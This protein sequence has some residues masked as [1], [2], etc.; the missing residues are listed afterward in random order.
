MTRQAFSAAVR[1]VGAGVGAREFKF[2]AATS[3]LGRDGH[4]I[5]PAGIALNNYKRNP[6]VLFQHRAENPVA[7]CTGIAVVDGEL[8]GSAEFPPLGTSPLADEVCGLVKSG[9]VSAVS[10]GFEPTETEP[11]DPKRPRSGLR[12][13]RC[14]LLECSLVTIPAD[15]GAIV[16][17]RHWRSNM[18]SADA[19]RCVRES[20]DIHRSAI[21]DHRDAIRGHERAAR[22][23]E[24]L[25]AR[26]GISRTAVRSALA[27]HNRALALHRRAA[28]EH[29]NCVDELDD[30]LDRSV[31]SNPANGD[32]LKDIHNSQSLQTSAGVSKGTSSYTPLSRAQR[33]AELLALAGPV[34]GDGGAVGGAVGAAAIRDAEFIRRLA[35]CQAVAAAGGALTRSP[36]RAER[37][38]R[39][40]RLARPFG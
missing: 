38:E 28:D 6:V 33:Q 1:A 8:R 24:G 31:P 9:V 17:E 30:L 35:H 19:R 14:E 5:I 36:T 32:G 2:V 26:G 10:I 20:I 18:L 23:V 16:T 3:Q 15:V 25:V 29:D 12:I 11:L 22:L 7:R 34:V 21:A 40:R 37:Q 27:A 4:V 13:T 39:A